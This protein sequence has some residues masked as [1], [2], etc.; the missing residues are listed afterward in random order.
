[1][2]VI[3]RYLLFMVVA[4]STALAGIAA[5]VAVRAE[6]SGAGALV[7]KFVDAGGRSSEYITSKVDAAGFNDV[8]YVG[9]EH[10]LYDIKARNPDGQYVAI[11][12]DPKTGELLKDPGTGKVR[13]KT[14][15]PPDPDATPLSWEGIIS[16][17]KDEGY[18]EVYAIHY[19]HQLYEVLA[20]DAQ[21]RVFELFVNPN[22]GELLR[23]P[24][25][26]KP[27]SER[28]DNK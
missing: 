12:L 9:F 2:N 27:L 6:V 22:T 7:Q 13:Y 23:H 14:V 16:Q 19:D 21:N 25:T 26:G 28:V 20:R 18:V 11:K 5:P 10:G 1:M 24:T 8:Y 4:L 3:N 15:T 17:I